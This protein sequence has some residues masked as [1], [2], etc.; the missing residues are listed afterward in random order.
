MD[1]RK[2]N[3]IAWDNES[4]LGNKW[5]ILLNTNEI[6]LAKKGIYKL[7]ITPNK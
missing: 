4:R 3:E 5:T 6:I 7:F 1:I 2:Y